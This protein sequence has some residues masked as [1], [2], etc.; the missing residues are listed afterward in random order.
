MFLSREAFGLT[1]VFT[2]VALGL[3]LFLSSYSITRLWR[4]R[5]QKRVAI[6]E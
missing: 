3:W 4:R 1:F 5:Q 6:V 2:R